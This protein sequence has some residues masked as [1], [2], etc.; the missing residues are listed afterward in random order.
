MGRAITLN[1]L[2]AKSD[3]AASVDAK[4]AEKLKEVYHRVSLEIQRLGRVTPEKAVELLQ[5]EL[6]SVETEN[7]QNKQM[8]D[9]LRVALD[10]QGRQV[11][12]LRGQSRA[13][14]QCRVES[15]FRIFS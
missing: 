11:E 15:I 1:Q 2:A 8:R 6:N 4:Q 9:D 14:E 12:T 7:G 10:D 5:A 13:L 3:F